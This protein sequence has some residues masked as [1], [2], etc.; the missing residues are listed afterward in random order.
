MMRWGT[1]ATAAGTASMMRVE[2]S[3]AEP[4]G[5]YSPHVSIGR[6]TRRQTTPGAVSTSSGRGAVAS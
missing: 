1:P 2:T 4:A 5:T 6:H 3:G